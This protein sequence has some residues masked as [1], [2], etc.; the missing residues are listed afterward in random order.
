MKP[1]GKILN[2]PYTVV[3]KGRGT[4]DSFDKPRFWITGGIHPVTGEDY[5]GSVR[6]AWQKFK[7]ENSSFLMFWSEPNT[8]KLHSSIVLGEYIPFIGNRVIFIHNNN[9]QEQHTDHIKHWED[10]GYLRN[11]WKVFTIQKIFSLLK[12]FSKGKELN[13]EEQENLNYINNTCYAVLDELH[14]YSKNDQQSI[15]MITTVIEYMQQN[16]LKLTLGTTATARGVTAAWEIFGGTKLLIEQKKSTYRTTPQELDVDGWK[17]VPTSYIW[18]DCKTTMEDIVGSSW[19]YESQSESTVLDDL[20]D[21]QHDNGFDKSELEVYVKNRIDAGVNHYFRYQGEV[22]GVGIMSI[23]GIQ[24]ALDAEQKYQSQFQKRGFQCIAW[25]S[26]S[27]NNHPIY[28]NNEKK[29]LK[30]LFDPD[31]PLRFVF[32]NGMLQEGTNKP[33]DVAY[34]TNFSKQNPDKSIQFIYRAK[35]GFIIIDAPI[36]ETLKKNPYVSDLLE[37][38]IEKSRQY[39]SPEE[40][41]SRVEKIEGALIAESLRQGS[42]TEDGKEPHQGVDIDAIFD[43]LIDPNPQGSGGIIV[44]AHKVFVTDIYHENKLVK[45]PLAI[46]GQI[47]R[48]LNQKA[49]SAIDIF[50]EDE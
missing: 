8:S 24:N 27:K 15:Q 16:Q 7:K 42:I 50:G 43:S 31:H 32:V 18:A 40:L 36:I 21:N 9:L 12:K 34:M 44:N 33:F 11:S 25:N 23:N 41:E 26:E 39:L 5:Q 20:K 1:Y 13:E 3:E 47:H 17:P 46:G 38:V 19:S 6:W 29:M 35:E 48:S 2:Q 14:R 37:N 10:I 45:V 30:D 22:G 28:R 49:I 4:K